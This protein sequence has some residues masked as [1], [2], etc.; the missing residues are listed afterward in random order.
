MVSN[1]QSSLIDLAAP[2]KTQRP[3]KPRGDRKTGSSTKDEF[4]KLMSDRQPADRKS[5]DLTQPNADTAQK[6]EEET[7]TV[8]VAKTPEEELKERM[9]LAA[10]AL[11]Q[12][13]VQ[14]QTEPEAPVMPVEALTAAEAVEA[15]NS[16]LEAQQPVKIP[17]EETA[18]T[19]ENALPQEEQTQPQKV[20]QARTAPQ[21]DRVEVQAEQPK[22]QPE[23]KDDSLVKKMNME[24]G[25][26]AEAPLFKKVE[27][28]PVKV[29]EAAPSEK[30]QEPPVNQVH[31]RLAEAMRK[32]ETSLEMELNPKNLGKVKVELIWHK[33]GSMHV[34]LH[35]DKPKTQ[36]LLDRDAGQLELLL[37]RSNQ[38]EIHV[39]S[40]RQQDSAR[41]Q[42]DEGEQGRQQQGHQQEN[43]RRRE[44]RDSGE[45][46]LHQ[47][48]LGLTPVDETL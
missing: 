22:A 11:I 13:P 25:A 20:Q 7:Q 35:A 12:P 46:F 6:A 5:D 47:L 42:Y 4:Q 9:M 17:A 23:Q 10:M 21:E 3:D 36:A 29:G 48:R 1:M 37:G 28:V 34:L 16:A 33:D 18:L 40:P 41:P 2:Q 15:Q 8:P 14:T 27:T 39:E 24:Q 31:D 32:G 45:D 19:E 44:S 38:Q 43:Q 26:D 30:V